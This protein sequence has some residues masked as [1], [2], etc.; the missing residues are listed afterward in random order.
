MF[1]SF[2]WL[3]ADFWPS[4]DMLIKWIKRERSF[5]SPKM[6]EKPVQYAP[7]SHCRPQ[8]VCIDRA[9]ACAIHSWRAHRLRCLQLSSIPHLRFL[10]SSCPSRLL[11]CPRSPNESVWLAQRWILGVAMAITHVEPSRDQ[12][13]LNWQEGRK[14]SSQQQRPPRGGAQKCSLSA[15]FGEH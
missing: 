3:T 13:V 10:L 11:H 12:G 14:D 4:E 8:N 9:P 6:S 5:F 7:W 15:D 1:L 2:L